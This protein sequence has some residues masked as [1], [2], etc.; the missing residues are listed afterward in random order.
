MCAWHS[1]SAV[2]VLC[3][4][5]LELYLHSFYSISGCFFLFLPAPAKNM[6]S[7]RMEECVGGCF[8]VASSSLS[9]DLCPPW[10]LKET[11]VFEAELLLFVAPVCL[12]AVC[13]SGS[14]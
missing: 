14:P 5:F 9:V 3:F 8:L 7:K 6:C 2:N 4:A 1:A 13:S 11:Y 10:L 12:D